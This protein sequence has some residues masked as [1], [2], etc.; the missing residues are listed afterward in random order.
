M[1]AYAEVVRMGCQGGD[2]LKQTVM[3]T[4]L[5][6]VTLGII[7]VQGTL[8]GSPFVTTLACLHPNP[9]VLYP[10]NISVISAS[11]AKISTLMCANHYFIIAHKLVVTRCKIS[12]G[13]RGFRSVA[14]AIWNS[15]PSNVRSYET[16]T[17]SRHSADTCTWNLIF[18]IQPLL[19]PPISAPLIRSRPW[20]L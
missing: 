10:R 20:R 13:G 15:L 5:S 6:S 2:G 17:V 19:L 9:I 4:Q 12:F 14:P 11:W 8:Q 1:K 7:Q 18:S 3:F 16:L